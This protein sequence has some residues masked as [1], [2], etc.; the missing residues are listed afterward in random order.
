MDFGGVSKSVPTTAQNAVV[1]LDQ[2]SA[3]TVART[4][5]APEATVQRIRETAAVRLETSSASRDLAAI[6]QALQRAVD[7]RL[8]VDDQTRSLVFKARDARSG[9]VIT[10][11]PTEQT[12]KLRA[13]LRNVAEAAAQGSATEADK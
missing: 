4:E 1:R 3:S 10:Q 8:E 12:L 7:R 6:E 9:E 5:L 11:I 13:Y 2:T